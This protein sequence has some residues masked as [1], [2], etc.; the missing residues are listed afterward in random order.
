M[1]PFLVNANV[2]HAIDECLAGA[3]RLGQRHVLCWALPPRRNLPPIGS[4]FFSN[5]IVWT[6][7]FTAVAAT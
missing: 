3:Q 7:H 6:H 4:L 2:A 1:A 5:V